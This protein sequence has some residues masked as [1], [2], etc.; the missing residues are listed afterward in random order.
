FFDRARR[1]V[2]VRRST[3]PFHR[4]EQFFWPRGAESDVCPTR[5]A[6]F[7]TQVRRHSLVAPEPGA[8]IVN[9]RAKWTVVTLLLGASAC[10]TAHG[11][12]E[13]ARTM[14]ASPPEAAAATP[15]AARRG[16]ALHS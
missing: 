14:D 10:A 11:V 13:R 15:D 7:R 16:W 6:R 1:A 3:I 12:S 2:N 4:S 5:S 9:T 8:S